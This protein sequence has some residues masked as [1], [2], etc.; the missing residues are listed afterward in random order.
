[1]K[2]AL[3][4]S[5][6]IDGGGAPLV[7]VT[8]GPHVLLSATPPPPPRPPPR[9][10]P[11]PPRPPRPP[12]PAAAPPSA[13]G[14]ATV[15]RVFFTGSMTMFSEPVGVVRTYQNLPSGSQLTFTVSPKTRPLRPGASIFVARS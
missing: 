10:P 6:D 13:G 3:V 2:I 15:S 7:P 1:M 12:P 14:V 9:P 4:P 8:F 5:G 11:P